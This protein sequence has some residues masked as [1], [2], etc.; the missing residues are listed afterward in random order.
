M[1]KITIP[2]ELK[3][4]KENNIILNNDL[5]LED[6]DKEQDL[7]NLKQEGIYNSDDSSALKE[8]SLSEDILAN[9]NNKNDDDLNIDDNELDDLLET[10][11]IHA[12]RLKL[13]VPGE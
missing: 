9:K 11:S 8:S 12:L 1:I 4:K 2:K 7:D 6:I 5:K 10:W 13:R 3:T